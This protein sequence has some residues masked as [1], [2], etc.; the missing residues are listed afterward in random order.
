MGVLLWFINQ[1]SHHWGAPSDGIPIS[2]PM[3]PME[4]GI[5]QPGFHSLHQSVEKKTN[6]TKNRIEIGT[7][8]GT[9][10]YV[11]LTYLN[12]STDIN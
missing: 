1:C 6:M 5:S 3:D 9:F 11:Y 8:I 2:M 10:I 4:C 12:C 7:E